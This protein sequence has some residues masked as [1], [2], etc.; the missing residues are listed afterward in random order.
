M[1]K[2]RAVVCHYVL[3]E[4][5]DDPQPSSAIETKSSP[6]TAKPKRA[7][8]PASAALILGADWLLFSGTALSAGT[9]VLLSMTLGF[10]VGTVA[11]TLLQH[12]MH[13]DKWPT[14][15]LKGFAS[16]L[17][18]GAPFPIGG[19]VLGGSILALS[20]LDS[21]RKLRLPDTRA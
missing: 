3:E 14:A 11:V 9:G 4:I 1:A 8:H 19:T 18:V 12:Y 16:G 7:L 20:G 15:L 13:R 21:F 2:C 10:T 5:M 6:P 17:V